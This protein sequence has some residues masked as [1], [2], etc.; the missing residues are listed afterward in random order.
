MSSLQLLVSVPLRMM[1]LW[2]F[3]GMIMQVPYAVFVSKFLS[4]NYGN[5]AVWISLILGQPVA[6][7]M[8]Y[9]DY[10]VTHYEGTLFPYDCIFISRLFN[11][12]VEKVPCGAKNSHRRKHCIHFSDYHP[13]VKCP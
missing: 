12:I 6:I 9:H 8:Y 7:L 1:K 10:F 3:T 11:Y 5:I 13:S 4:G 2:A